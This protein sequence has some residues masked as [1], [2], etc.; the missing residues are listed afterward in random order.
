MGSLQV[1]QW[2]NNMTASRIVAAAASGV[3]GAGPDVDEVYGIRM[4]E[5]TSASRTITNDIDLSG[6]GGL[7]WVKKYTSTD[8]HALYDT[9]RGA[10]K[11]ITTNDTDAESTISQGVK[12]FTS[13]GF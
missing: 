7:V 5:G 13:A 8:A 10:T 2:D 9:V 11:Y 6:E 12:A 4:Q 3:G 1:R